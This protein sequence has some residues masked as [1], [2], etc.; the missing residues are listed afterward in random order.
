MPLG[1]SENLIKAAYGP[2]DFSGIYKGFQRTIDKLAAEEKAYKQMAAREYSQEYNKLDQAMKGVKEADSKLYADKF[3]EWKKLSMVKANT[4]NYYDNIDLAMKGDAKISSLYTDIYTSANDSKLKA[5]EHM[6]MW[7]DMT[8]HPDNY[9]ENARTLFKKNVI[10]QPTSHIIQN[11]TDDPSLYINPI[12]NYDKKIVAEIDKVAKDG[13]VKEFKPIV[14]VKGWVGRQD[15]YKDIPR[16]DL[17]WEGS[18]KV[19]GNQNPNYRGAAANK[20]LGNFLSEDGKVNDY[21]KQII[22]RFNDILKI[23]SD[24][25]KHDIRGLGLDKNLDSNLYF[26]DENS[27]LNTISNNKANA[28]A[29]MAA[30]E[31]YIKKYETVTYNQGMNKSIDP[32]SE[33]IWAKNLNLSEREQYYYDTHPGALALQKTDINKLFAGLS[34]SEQEQPN[35]TRYKK[36][37]INVYN[38]SGFMPGDMKFITSKKSSVESEPDVY[39]YLDDYKKDLGL[40]DGNYSAQDIADA[41]KKANE[42][43]AFRGLDVNA[44]SFKNGRVV[45]FP[46]LKS[47]K[48]VAYVF[49]DPSTQSG[50]NFLTRETKKHIAT[51]KQ[52]AG[53]FSNIEEDNV[54]SAPATR[55]TPRASTSY[56]GNVR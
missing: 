50:R 7:K 47:D 24:P 5:K 1:I 44:E 25:T 16:Y 20:F 53:L 54:P 42:N 32:M 38:Q 4:P 37:I 15:E 21:G 33:K 52:E 31:N 26:K 43:N 29:T 12:P 9:I 45:V 22:S 19:F 36:D 55:T 48:S 40:V 6:D 28:A 8:T 39:G 41:M 56:G 3:N 23:Q 35:T 27:L 18:H 34:Q 51:K 17:L 13:V 49:A 30:M 10:D 2:Q 46:V 14:K 11:N